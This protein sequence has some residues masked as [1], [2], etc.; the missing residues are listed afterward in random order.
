MTE[1]YVGIDVSK[2]QLDVAV[3]GTAPAQF[4]NT[5]AGHDALLAWLKP[6]GPALIVVEPT[7][8]YER[9]IVVALSE[10]TLPV[11]VV[12]A[13]QVRDFAKAVGTRAKTD[14][15]DAFVLARYAQ[16]VQPVA[17]EVI[18]AQQQQLAELLARRRQVV[19]MLVSEKNR[20]GLVGAAVRADIQAHI[21]FLEDRQAGLDSALLDLV[22]ADPSW[23]TKLE[24]C[25]SV[26]GIG[27]TTALTLLAD[28]PELGAL[29]RQQ[30]AALVGLAPFARDSGQRRG[31][32]RTGGGRAAVRSA[33]YIA[34]WTA[35]R[36]NPVLRA[37][38]AH[39]LDQG[40][41]KQVALIAC[42]RKLLTILN[43]ML[44]DL[45]PWSPPL[46]A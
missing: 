26:P 42:A 24:L 29:T 35:V 27:V 3:L 23:H 16:A 4:P 18:S 39:L 11:A 17:R 14:T 9:A 22:Q 1:V 20:L 7:G 40:K 45:K 19:S 2:A 8:G 41:P 36:W 32:R 44:R 25:Q 10:A 33:L 38:Y 5:P 30:V 13:R 31:Q 12:N 6:Q 46:T 28:L 37:T 34:A 43:A 15:L 21:A